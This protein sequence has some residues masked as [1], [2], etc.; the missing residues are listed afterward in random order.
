MQKAWFVV[1]QYPIVAFILAIVEC[2]TQAKGIYCLDSKDKHFAYFWLNIIQ[3][4]SVALAIGAIIQFYSKFNSYMKE[5]KPLAKLMA[6]KL[7]VGLVF[8]EKII[9]T[10]LHSTNTLKPSAAMSYA[11]VHIGLPTMIICIQMVPFAFFFHYAYSTKPYQIL[12]ATHLAGSQ[13]CPAVDIATGENGTIYQK[14][15]EGGA[16]GVYAW[17]A[18]VNPLEILQEIKSTWHMLRN[19]KAETMHIQM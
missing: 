3:I 11:D 17:C 12:S 4:I 5:H 8:L 2:I 18:F 1:L 6:F 15:Y 19:A 14:G 10:I 13:Q 9:F 16:V 7:V